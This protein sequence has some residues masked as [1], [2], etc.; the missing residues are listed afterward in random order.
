MEQPKSNEVV[1]F[2]ARELGWSLE[3]IGK[4]GIQQANELIQELTHQKAVEV[5]REDYRFAFLASVVCNLVSKNPMTPD[6]FIGQPPQ[7]GTNEEQ[8]FALAKKL[9]R[10]KK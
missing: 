2:L 8:L 1:V 9:R 10:R 3:Q 6:D 7:K 4:L 5:Y